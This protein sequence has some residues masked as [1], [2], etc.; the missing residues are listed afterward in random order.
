M[1]NKGFHDFRPNN[2]AL[3]QHTLKILDHFLVLLCPANRAPNQLQGFQVA[4]GA[5]LLPMAVMLEAEELFA[6]FL[7]FRV[8]NPNGLL[9]E[10]AVIACWKNDGVRC[11]EICAFEICD[12]LV[13]FIESV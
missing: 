10:E 11:F 3:V 9:G 13:W 7:A 4:L 12:R 5:G 8:Q 1:S 6:E 2:D